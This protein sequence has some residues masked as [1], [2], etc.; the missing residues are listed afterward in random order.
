MLDK[1]LRKIIESSKL[2]ENDII[3]YDISSIDDILEEVSTIGLFSNQKLLIIDADL[4]FEIEDIDKLINYLVNKKDDNYLI[5][6][7]HSD[8]V[9]TRRKIYKTISSIGT[10]MELKKDASYINDYIKNILKENN[11]EMDNFS[12]NQFLNKAGSDLDNIK[13]ELDKLM[14]YKLEDKRITSD[15]VEKLVSINFEEQIFAL[16]NAIIANNVAKSL[17][18]YHDFLNKNMKE[19]YIIATIASQF[20][21]SYQVKRLY[22]QNK[23]QDEIAK[24]LDAK[25][26]RVYVTIQNSYNYTENDYLRYLKKLAELDKNIKLNLMNRDF[27]ELFLINKD[28]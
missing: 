2:T 23:S 14:L 27:F 4:I 9:D 6:M 17:D 1:E 12:I 28:M 22:N 8:K 11:F 15:D 18:L 7:Y 25:P 5:F 3:K 26:G 10:V 24:I 20:R 13:N 21:F 19:E 16:S